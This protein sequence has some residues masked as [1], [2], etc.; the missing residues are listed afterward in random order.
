MPGSIPS[1]SA[2][3]EYRPSPAATTVPLLHV[4]LP[5]G[6]PSPPHLTPSAIANTGG[7]QMRNTLHPDT[8]E[9]VGVHHHAIGVRHPRGTPHAGVLT[10]K[11][12]GRFD[13]DEDGPCTPRA[14]TR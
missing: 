9:P 6:A 13:S 11:D 7:T 10:S 1:L 8:P 2:T 4:S 3:S 5:Q 14:R 12:D